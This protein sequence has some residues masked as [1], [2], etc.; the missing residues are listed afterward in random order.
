[1]RGTLQNQV[2]SPPHGFYGQVAAPEFQLTAVRDYCLELRLLFV[3][4]LCA[5]FSGIGCCSEI[6]YRS[7]VVVNLRNERINLWK[8]D[9]ELSEIHWIA[10]VQFPCSRLCFLLLLLVQVF[11]AIQILQRLAPATLSFRTLSSVKRMSC[12]LQ[13]IL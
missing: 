11:D 12:F 3:E 9:R 4:F 13:K 2:P 8:I 7:M 6:E 5:D 1:M 10:N